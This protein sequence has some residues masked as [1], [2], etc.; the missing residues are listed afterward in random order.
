MRLPQLPGAL[1]LDFSGFPYFSSQNLVAPVCAVRVACLRASFARLAAAVR[2]PPR[3]LAS[4]RNT[5]A[6]TRTQLNQEFLGNVQPIEWMIVDTC[7]S[8]AINSIQN[9][10]YITRIC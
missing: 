7:Y 8:C 1:Q 4:E 5:S 10:T 2:R 6:A 9:S 3:S